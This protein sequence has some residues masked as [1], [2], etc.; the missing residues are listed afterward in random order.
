MFK[1]KPKGVMGEIAENVMYLVL[2][3]VLAFSAYAI[4]GT[5]L[6]TK[7]PIVTVVSGSMEPVLHRGDLLVLKGA[8]ISELSFG[9]KTGTIIVYHQPE[10]D[11]LIVHRAWKP[12]SDGTINTWGDANSVPDPWNVK[13]EWIR[14]KM[15]LRIPYLGYPR[16][17]LQDIQSELFG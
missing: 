7:N 17:W 9:R 8:N 5:A 4:L 16:L 6:D 2:G 3:V 15:V 11:Q 14:G 13:P 12:N 1:S 10:R